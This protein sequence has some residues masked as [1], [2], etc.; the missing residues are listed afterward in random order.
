MNRSL[1]KPATLKAA[2]AA[3]APGT[4]LT[5]RAGCARGP[6]HAEAWSA[7]QRQCRHR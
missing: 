2:I 1:G 3:H 4:G 7:D 6:H 5:R